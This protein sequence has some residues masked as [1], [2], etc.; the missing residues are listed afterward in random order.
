[1]RTFTPPTRTF[2][3]TILPSDSDDDQSPAMFFRPA[4]PVGVN[5]FLW[6]DNTVQET[7][8]PLADPRINLDGTISPGL[9]KMWAGGRT[10][11]ISDSEYQ[12]L[13]TA[14]YFASLGNIA[15]LDTTTFDSTD[16]M[17]A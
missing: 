8:P 12:I 7:Q 6:T 14:G 10:H 5:V 11:I 13:L 4:L 15:T 16:T 1:M 2:A 3:P 9:R 17:G